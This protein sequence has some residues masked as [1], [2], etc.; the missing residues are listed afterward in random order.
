MTGATELDRPKETPQPFITPGRIIA[1]LVLVG[2]LAAVFAT[3]LHEYLSLDALKDNRQALLDAVASNFLLTAL[4]FIAIYAVAVGL[5]LPGALWLTIGG[6]FVFGVLPATVFVTV[7]A[8]LGATIV[9][10]L[11]KYVIGDA[12][13]SRAGGAIKKMEA[14]FQENALSYLLVLRLV[15]LFPFFVVNLVPAFLGV[16][17]T[18]YVVGT[19]LGIIPGVFVYALVGAG[20]GEVLDRGEEVNTAAILNPQVL[21]ALIGLAVLALIPVV[22][23]KLSAKKNIAEAPDV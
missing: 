21:G 5:S 8:T 22:Y 9:F 3:G 6:G 20:F 1:V 15:P 4:A 11:A 17:L 18:T 7:G 16:R 14:G 19:F 12:L 23:K 13:R 2:A 10:L